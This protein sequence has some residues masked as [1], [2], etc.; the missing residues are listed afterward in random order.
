MPYL[1]EG[2]LYT[3]ARTAANLGIVSPLPTY[4]GSGFHHP[5]IDLPA[6]NLVTSQENIARVSVA[7]MAV[8]TQVSAGGILAHVGVTQQQTFN[9]LADWMQTPAWEVDDIFGAIFQSKYTDNLASSGLHALMGSEL[10]AELVGQMVNLGAELMGEYIEMIPVIGWIIGSAIDIGSMVREAMVAQRAADFPT[11]YR[12]LAFNPG[13]DAT[14][15]NDYVRPMIDNT[16]GQGAPTIISDWT[17]MFM[18]PGTTA[19]LGT[20]SPFGFTMESDFTIAIVPRFPPLGLGIIPGSA[21]LHQGIDL[22]R[23]GRVRDLGDFLP[24]AAQ[25]GGLLWQRVMVEGPAMFT[26]DT[27]RLMYWSGYLE[28]LRQY[29]GFAPMAPDRTYPGLGGFFSDAINARVEF[30]TEDVCFSSLGKSECVNS[31]GKKKGARRWGRFANNSDAAKIID[32]YAS[33]AL[34]GWADSNGNYLK[35]NKQGNLVV[36]FAQ[37]PVQDASGTHHCTPVKAVRLLRE[38]QFQSLD[39]LMVAYLETERYAA[40]QTDTE[41]RNRF[42]ERRAQLVQHPARCHIDLEAVPGMDSLDGGIW[43]EALVNSG[44]GN[45]AVC[46]PG[47]QIAAAPPAPLVAAPLP[48]GM[49]GKLTKYAVGGLKRKGGGALPLAMAAAALILLSR[50][51]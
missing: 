40:F 45:P 47:M 16:P 25:Q 36:D 7:N 51:K 13:L 50:R 17:D 37:D 20:L 8:G 49:E 35:F 28:K 12:P 34:F 39:T 26:V 38:R 14:V 46:G 23:H 1:A 11:L 9:G 44:V 3:A 32:H 27:S 18:P 42:N 29:L 31:D 22:D 19:V 10:V 24:T 33:P 48:T 15:Y 4:D 41:L 43:L 5:G 6:S 21:M 30:P 2:D